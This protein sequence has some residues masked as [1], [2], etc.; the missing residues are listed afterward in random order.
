[1]D[2]LVAEP[3]EP[4]VLRWL[5]R[6]LGRIH[7][8]GGR[9]PFAERPTLDIAS[10]GEQPRDEILHSAFLPAELR[11]TAQGGCATT[12]AACAACGLCG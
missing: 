10:F 12:P 11:E 6:F 9:R 8:V 7:A 4:E 2:L 3:L 5:G 1:M